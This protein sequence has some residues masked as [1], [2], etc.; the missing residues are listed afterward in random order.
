MV[1]LRLR[2]G[3]M[4]RYAKFQSVVFMSK[5][6]TNRRSADVVPRL[7]RLDCV[8]ERLVPMVMVQLTSTGCG[9]QI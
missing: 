7:R 1:I 8:D 5:I 9:D 2:F 6:R 3:Q 4:S